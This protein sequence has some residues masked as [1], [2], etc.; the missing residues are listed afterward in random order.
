MQSDSVT[1]GVDALLHYLHQHE[2]VSLS[3]IAKELK[4]SEETVKLW[5]D[6]L[7]EEQV[8]GIEY[9][10]TK[11]YIYIN[12]PQHNKKSRV[13][14]KEKIAIDVFKKD[15]FKRAKA[16]NIPENQIE[17]LWKDH[18]TNQ[19]ELDK[20]HFFREARKRGL[21]DIDSLWEEYKQSK[22]AQ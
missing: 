4:L 2:K 21:T 1:T 17:Y 14:E 9:K 11:P 6:F 15:F 20:Q 7:V 10:F 16:S 5:V 3:D 12:K 19:L 13:I 18:L 8:V 22:L